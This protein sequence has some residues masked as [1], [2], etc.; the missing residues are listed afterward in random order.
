MDDYTAAADKLRTEM[1]HMEHL[2]DEDEVRVDLALAQAKRV[3]REST[4]VVR[5]LARHRDSYSPEGTSA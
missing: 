4:M 5:A 2:L 3:R 1:L